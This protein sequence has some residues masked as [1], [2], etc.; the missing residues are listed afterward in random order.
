MTTTNL[1]HPFSASG[2]EA[3]ITEH[4]L[5][6][7][8]CTNCQKIYLPPTAICPICHSESLE[9]S[10]VSGTGKLAGFTVIYVAP[11]SMIAQGFGRDKPYIAGIVELAE[12]PKVSAR[13]TG[14]DPLHPEAIQI[15]TP[16]QVDFIEYN[17]GEIVKVNLAFK[18]V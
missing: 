6:A 3:F 15:G 14:F 1:A 4:K 18:A 8:H 2:F 7:V 17:Q 12:G 10:E 13:I 9:W 5:A 11:S 16:L